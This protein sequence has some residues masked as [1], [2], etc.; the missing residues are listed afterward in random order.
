MFS[1]LAIHSKVFVFIQVF[2]ESLSATM[3][4]TK[5]PQTGWGRQRIFLKVKEGS[6]NCC[7]SYI[8]NAAERLLE[9][10]GLSKFHKEESPLHNLC[11]RMQLMFSSQA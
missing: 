4:V 8:V 1:A 2:S 6:A 9:S 3:L 5:K 10:P 7:I 11:A